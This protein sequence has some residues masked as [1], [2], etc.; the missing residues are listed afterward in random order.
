MGD[1]DVK[2][3]L[4]FLLEKKNETVTMFKVTL[5]IFIS[6]E[7]INNLLVLVT[8]VSAHGCTL[9]EKIEALCVSSC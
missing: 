4:R 9:L 5:H 7:G 8:D 3:T 2:E 1:L 6:Q